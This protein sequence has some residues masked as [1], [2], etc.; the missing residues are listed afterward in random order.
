M[1]K[2]YFST[3]IRF[4]VIFWF[5]FYPDCHLY[6]IH[7][8]SIDYFC[9]LFFC[10]K[11]AFNWRLVSREKHKK[12][13]SISFKSNCGN[14]SLNTI[15]LLHFSSRRNLRGVIGILQIMRVRKKYT[16][17]NNPSN[18]RLFCTF[19]FCVT[20][21]YKVIVRNTLVFNFERSSICLDLFFTQWYINC[22]FI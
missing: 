19:L 16:P 5:T 17:N 21:I 12:V 6:P 20:A 8:T 18:E 22:N 9:I 4:I 1:I 13:A 10:L 3:E 14:G 2:S 11:L 7:S 15:K